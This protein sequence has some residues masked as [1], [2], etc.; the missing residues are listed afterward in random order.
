MN[1]TAAATL[2][3]RELARAISAIELGNDEAS[4][5]VR[6]A[7][8]RSG[9][10]FVV[11]I[12]GPPGTGKSTLIG[13]LITQVRAQNQTVAVIAVD[14][15]SPLSGGALLGDRV[16]MGAHAHDA[17]VFIRS[18]ATRGEV[19]GLARAVANSVRILDAAG[20]AMILVETVGAGQ[21]DFRIATLADAVIVALMPETG[22]EVQT[23]KAGLLEVADI[24]VVNKA[25]LPG[26]DL[27]YASL[28]RSAGERE[29]WRVP[30]VRVSAKTGEGLPLLLQTLEQFRKHLQNTGTLGRR[31]ARRVEEELIETFTARRAGEIR[32]CLRRD[33][34]VGRI[35]Q[36]VLARELDPESAQRELEALVA[37]RAERP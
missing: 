22:D 25:D 4:H 19:G 31:R 15:T 37:A 13:R 16:R 30:V 32:A 12:T 29:G 36:R 21:G 5:L 7:H 34:Q 18:M 24:L 35:V 2:D 14:P 17:G 26:A 28:L 3:H 23:Y 9:Q 8:R 27:L 10:A 6:E 1:K 20:F 11:G 33:S